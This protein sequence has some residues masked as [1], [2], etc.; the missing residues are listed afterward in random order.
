M[1]HKLLGIDKP[2]TLWYK[3]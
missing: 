2:K 3:F 1:Y